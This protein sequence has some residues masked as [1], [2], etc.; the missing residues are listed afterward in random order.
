V[1]SI[2]RQKLGSDT[3]WDAIVVNL[4]TGRYQD[5]GDIYNW[6]NRGDFNYLSVP[7]GGSGLAYLFMSALAVSGGIFMSGKDRR[8]A[9]T[10]QSS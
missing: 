1:D 9:R 4:A 10:A 7:E 8:S 2:G 3:V 6:R 5:F